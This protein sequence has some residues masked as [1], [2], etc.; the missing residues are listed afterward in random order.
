MKLK[1]HKQVH[2]ISMELFHSAFSPGGTT[3]YKDLWQLSPQSIAWNIYHLIVAD[4][5]VDKTPL[6]PQFKGHFHAC[7]PSFC[8]DQKHFMWTMSQLGEW[9]VVA[10]PAS[11]FRF[12]NSTERFNG[13]FKHLKH[14]IHVRYSSFR[15]YQYT[16][17][18]N[19]FDFSVILLKIGNCNF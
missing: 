11:P 8:F 2:I 6:F 18:A 1:A 19:P 5:L 9:M 10:M 15:N 17:G 12:L 13:H 14:N 16:W 7:R 3:L 4:F